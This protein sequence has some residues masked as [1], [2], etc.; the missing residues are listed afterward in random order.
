M[1][2]CVDYGDEIWRHKKYDV[3]AYRQKKFDLYLGQE[4]RNSY[5]NKPAKFLNLG[6]LYKPG[7][8]IAIFLNFL[9]KK[10]KL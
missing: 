5:L 9:Q 6:I 3:M 2:K 10:G 4:K 7:T 8:R 1:T